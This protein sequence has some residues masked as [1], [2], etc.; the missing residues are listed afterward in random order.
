MKGKRRELVVPPS[1]EKRLSYQM[2]L[3]GE[4]FNEFVRR[5]LN[6]KLENLEAKQAEYRMIE[7]ATQSGMSA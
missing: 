2:S 7:H 5:C 4:G 3:T 6:E 1:L